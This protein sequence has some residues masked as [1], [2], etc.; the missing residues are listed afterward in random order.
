MMVI[1]HGY[2]GVVDRVLE[3]FVKLGGWS[4]IKRLEVFKIAKQAIKQRSICAYVFSTVAYSIV[5][6]SVKY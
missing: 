5:N 4:I 3:I 1:I 2:I 6:S